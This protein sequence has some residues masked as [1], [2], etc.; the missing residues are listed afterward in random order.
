M[1]QV[2]HD[3]DLGI[4]V[5]VEGCRGVGGNCWILDIF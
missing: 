3:E 1:I 4:V 2:Q 5:V